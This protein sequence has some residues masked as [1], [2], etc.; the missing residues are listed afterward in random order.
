MVHRFPPLQWACAYGSGVIKQRGYKA[1]EKPLIDMLFVVDDALQW[2]TANLQTNRRHYSLLARMLGVH[3]IAAIQK[4]YGAGVWFHT[5][6][7]VDNTLIKYGVTEL[8]TV[9]TD[10]QHWS[11][12]YIAGRL[13]KPVLILGDRTAGVIEKDMYQNCRSALVTALLL[14]LTSTPSTAATPTA[15]TISD[16]S[17]FHSIAQLSYT[18]DIRMALKAENPHKVSNIVQNNLSAFRE[19]Y[20]PHMDWL[21]QLQ[22]ATIDQHQLQVHTSAA[23]LQLLVKHLPSDI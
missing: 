15:V 8:A 16:G 7:N 10:L 11:T 3:R 23:T 2:H 13:Q 1:D 6:I 4:H 9:R 14:L 17:L 20:Q 21:Q 18:G 22:I 12:L 19:L 5:N